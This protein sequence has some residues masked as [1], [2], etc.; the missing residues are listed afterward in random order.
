MI[1]NKRS[2]PALAR[3]IIEELGGVSRVAGLC[4][5]RP[6]SVVYWKNNGMPDYRIQYLRLAFPRLKC[7]SMEKEASH[8]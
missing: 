8:A 2:C 7:W 3:A 1:K 6:P 5:V 4:R